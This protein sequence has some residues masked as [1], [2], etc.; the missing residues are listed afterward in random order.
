MKVAS[1]KTQH[2]LVKPE[3]PAAVKTESKPKIP[4][5]WRKMSCEDYASKLNGMTR[6][7]LMQ[8]MKALEKALSSGVEFPGRDAV[9]QKLDLV[10]K[11]LNSRSWGVDSFV[12][13]I[14]RLRT[15]NECATMS[16]AELQTELAELYA[17]RD[18]EKEIAK[19]A[20]ELGFE[21]TSQFDSNYDKDSPMEQRIGAI[22]MELTRRG[23]PLKA[24]EKPEIPEHWVKMSREDYASQLNG[25][26]RG[27]LK[28]EMEA[29]TQALSSGVAF[30]GRDAVAQKLDLVKKELNSRGE[31]LEGFVQDI[32]RVVMQNHYARMP[33]AE[34]QAELA[35]LYAQR[36]SEKEVVSR[37]RELGLTGTNQFDSN[38]DQDSLME[39]RIGAIEAELTSRGEP[40]KA[41]EKP[42]APEKPQ[43]PAEPTYEEKWANAVRQLNAH[44]DL[45]DTAAGIGGRDGIIGRADLEA[46]VQNP[47]LPQELRDACQFLLDNPAVFNRLDVAAGIGR[48]DGRIGRADV[49]RALSELENTKS[50]PNKLPYFM[51]A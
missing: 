20:R 19:L 35:G 50:L 26:T 48:V 31:G 5:H 42:E 30:P 11:E 37:A 3:K 14:S 10:K 34:L 32:P 33:T 51:S 21:G 13:D 49:A 1:V 9:A 41:P 29:L 28:Q 4:E 43:P 44:F 2:A 38:Y 24:P 47:G 18:S 17:Q 27:Q 12:Q 45:L 40:L 15:Q 16:T 6:G 46:A 22:E 8:E 39:Q 25:M 36:D 7:Q 23:E